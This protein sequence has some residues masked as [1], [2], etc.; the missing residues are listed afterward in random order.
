MVRVNSFQGFFYDVPDELALRIPQL[1]REES[2]VTGPV[3]VKTDANCIR[4]LN[5]IQAAH[6]FKI[7]SLM[8]CTCGALAD[9]VKDERYL[10]ATCIDPRSKV[11][12]KAFRK[13][14]HPRLRSHKE[15]TFINV[16]EF[17]DVYYYPLLGYEKKM[18]ELFFR[19]ENLLFKDFSEKFMKYS[20]FAVNEDY[21]KNIKNM[22]KDK[23]QA[24]EHCS[25]LCQDIDS[26]SYKKLRKLNHIL[27]L[28]NDEIRVDLGLA[29]CLDIGVATRLA[30]I[31][32]NIDLCD[33]QFWA[34]CILSRLNFNNCGAVIKETVP[35]L[36]K[37][38]CS[39]RSNELATEAAITLT[40]VAN[41]YSKMITI[42]H[43]QS[44]HGVVEKL[45]CEGCGVLDYLAMILVIVCREK[46][47]SFS[48]K[49]K[50]V[51]PILGAL[52]QKSIAFCNTH[53][54][55]ACYAL[56]YLSYGKSVAV[57]LSIC[58]RLIVLSSHTSSFVVG[59]ALGVVGNIVRWGHTNLVEDLVK[60]CKLLQCLKENILCSRTKKIQKEGC[61]I[62]ANIAAR[63]TYINDIIDAGLLDSLCN[64]L[65][66]AE[67]DVKMEAAWA[68][69]YILPIDSYKYENINNYG[70]GML[71]YYD[72]NSMVYYGKLNLLLCLDRDLMAAAIRGSFRN[73]NCK[74]LYADE[75]R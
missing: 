34:V 44:L 28:I 32:K 58:K 11:D 13:V 17:G 50:V 69:I 7:V 8:D 31:L 45:T 24:L 72:C 73:H 56:S 52:L 40:H 64:L 75:C 60:T 39:L 25:Q 33:I 15:T 68:I 26:S 53:V 57:P 48:Q 2:E 16:S 41:A 21:F 18:E 38:I 19:N 70:S 5:L 9:Y 36:L 51:L 43:V 61:Q 3:K 29:R 54:V 27:V 20:D 74:I 30:L 49:V 47:L 59:P 55:R 14:F 42:S 23:N 62:I 46:G 1:L 71:M 6:K 22:Y 35:D 65:K 37:H 67:S 10:K 12:R 63:V 66:E 4:L